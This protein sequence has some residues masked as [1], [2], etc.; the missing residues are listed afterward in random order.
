[1]HNFLYQIANL[2]NRINIIPLLFQYYGYLEAQLEIE[3]FNVTGKIHDVQDSNPMVTLELG[4]GLKSTYG[5]GQ[6][7]DFHYGFMYWNTEPL[8]CKDQYNAI[9]SGNATMYIDSNANSTRENLL[10]VE[11]NDQFIGLTLEKNAHSFCNS[12]YKLYKTHMP[13]NISIICDY[14]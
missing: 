12:G 2:V 8:T 10:V 11:S 14:N 1:M 7:K 6:I 4:N 9:Y 3:I 13:G 5:V